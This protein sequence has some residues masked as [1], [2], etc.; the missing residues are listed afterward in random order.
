MRMIGP[1][2]G[3]L[4]TTALAVGPAASAQADAVTAVPADSRFEVATIKPGTPGESPGIRFLFSFTRVSTANTSVTDLLKYAYGLH[5]DQISGG[6]DE[7]MHQGYAI[8]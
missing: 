2:I 1:L 8:Q 5:A 4:L 3:I 6:A 7:L